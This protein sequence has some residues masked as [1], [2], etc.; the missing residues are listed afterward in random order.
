MNSNLKKLAA[1]A[2]A[3]CEARNGLR[4]GRI[5]ELVFED[6]LN[7]KDS[8]FSYDPMDAEDDY[9]RIN[10]AFAWRAGLGF[11]SK[12]RYIMDLFVYAIKMHHLKEH[13][14]KNL[15]IE[16]SVLKSDLLQREQSYPDVKA[17]LPVNEIMGIWV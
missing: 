4:F 3:L 11:E 2:P 6:E 5:A 8:V 9:N 10:P 15:H 16:T 17:I 12:K 7:N 13:G 14:D 1:L